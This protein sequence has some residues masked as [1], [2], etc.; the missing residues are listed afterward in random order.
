[1]G[2][3]GH[4]AFAWLILGSTAVDVAEWATVPVLLTGDGRRQLLTTPALKGH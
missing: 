1:M 2:R 4:D 3:R